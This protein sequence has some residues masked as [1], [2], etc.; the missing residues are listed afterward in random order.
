MLL[1]LFSV[2][3]G[4]G[5]LGWWARS[6]AA[7]E[8]VRRVAVQQGSRALGMDLFIGQIE[9]PSLVPLRV[10]A[11]TISLHATDAERSGLPLARLDEIEVELGSLWALREQRLE[12]ESLKITAPAVRLALV[13]GQL[14]DFAQLL[15]RR[16]PRRDPLR[17]Q[18][19]ELTVTGADASL[20][21][22]P[23][24]L[25]LELQDVALA[26]SQDE[27]GDGAGELQV[28]EVEVAIA[29]IRERS[30]LPPTPF[31]VEGSR[32][33]VPRADLPLR[34]GPLMLSGEVRLPSPPGAAEARP[35]SYSAL[36][37]AEVELPRLREIWGKLPQMEGALRVAVTARGEGGPPS[38]SF[39]VRG[40]DVAVHVEKPRPR[41]FRVGSPSLRGRV[42]G[43]LVH[44]E[45]SWVD[46]ALGRVD[47]EG[48]V[49][50]DGD[51]PFQVQVELQD[52]ELAALLDAVTVRHSWVQ[53]GMSGS[54]SLHGQLKGGFAAWGQA[55][56]DTRRLLVQ[57]GAWD[58]GGP[59]STILQVPRTH[60]STGITMGPR[61]CLLEP[62]RISAPGTELQAS[63]DFLFQRPVGLVIQV[64]GDRL[65]LADLGGAI[66]GQEV[67]G[68]GAISARVEGPSRDLDI[69][70]SLQLEDFTFRGWNFGSVQGDVH[71]HARD[72]LEFTRLV[73]RRGEST[74]ESEV[75]VLFA[76]VR[77]GGSRE[78]LEIDVE[79]AVPK[80]YGRAQ[81]LL[82]IFFGSAVDLRGPA[83]GQVH[84]WGRPAALQGRGQVHTGPVRYLWEDF[85][86]LDLRVDVRDGD[87]FLDDAWA[88]K[89][90][91]NAVF[92]RGLIGR[93]RRVDIELRIPDMGVEELRPV[94]RSLPLTG[95]L[96]GYA[97]LTGDLSAVDVATELRLIDSAYRGKP[98]PPST[99]E[100]TVRE[101]EAHGRADLLGGQLV[102]EG[103]LLL[104][105]LWPHSWGVAARDLQITPFLPSSVLARDS[106]VRASVDGRLEG[107]GTLRDGW[108]RVALGLDRLTLERAGQRLTNAPDTPIE[109]ALRDGA[110]CFDRVRLVDPGGGTDLRL[111]GS[112]RLDGPLDLSLSGPVDVRLVDL[113][114]DT[115]ERTEARSL[116]LAELHISGPSADALDVRGRAELRD[117][118]VKTVYFPHP[119]EISYAR[120]ALA[121][122]RLL[123]EEFEGT[124][125]GGK[126]THAAGSWIRLDG[127]SF[128]P[129]EYGLQARCFDCTLQYPSFMPPGTADITLRFAG[130]APDGLVL[131]GDIGVSSMV[132]REPIN[133]QRS[134]L[135][136]GERA[137]EN[138]AGSDQPPLFSFDIDVRSSEEGVAISNNL[139][140]LRGTARALHVGG[141]TNTVTLDGLLGIDSG[142]FRFKG[143][144]FQIEPGT[145]TFGGGS[146]W[147]PEMSI[148]MW[149]DVESRSRVYRITYDVSGPLNGPTLIASSDPAL[150]E[151]DIVSLLLFGLTEEDLARASLADLGAAIGNL[152]AS[153]ITEQAATEATSVLDTDGGKV[154]VQDFLPDRVEVVPVYTDT[155]GSTTLWVVGSKEIVPGLLDGEVGLGIRRGGAS[156]SAKARLQLLRNLYLE[157]SWLN[158]ETASTAYGNFG[159]DM[160]LE[161][162]LD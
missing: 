24:G 59:Y 25:G 19:G 18:I 162:E 14:R 135:A 47:F 118:L 127:S 40:E 68:W 141:D 124:L 129:R 97:H 107:V 117:A 110:L 81:D 125:G 31:A 10:R 85:E 155:T 146:D 45:P 131:S 142:S 60:V 8:L 26:F 62:A 138:L 20:S 33:A 76:D 111:E 132:L 126:L 136:I 89:A 69:G 91:G 36:A 21:V 50:L 153:T 93:D 159:L 116:N 34:T 38:V 13:G 35:L 43:K 44:I 56:I 109:V 32:V 106:T 1:A 63:V 28:G 15:R 72:D 27:Q 128:R 120:V 64:E 143:H 77:R 54:A 121:D 112:A 92:A 115:L 152:G 157:G 46:W 7:M 130:E 90:S 22:A 58:R 94:R 95:R 70:G 55:D 160:K 73:A 154:T 87:L 17:V 101:H 134:A 122:R 158:D 104:E 41:V 37:E 137:T 123:L 66:A 57:A 96:S 2:T 5:I 12:I 86:A 23:L 29:D 6:D 78:G 147:F 65:D 150:A 11:G 140:N 151:K 113:F 84:L 42:E 80:G 99:L 71:W 139:G 52:V 51:L 133:W 148:R 49:G 144:D 102:A 105:Q 39:D 75:R 161:L 119:I 103:Q 4:L 30:S 114:T 88:R 100:A 3:A 79:V 67:D 82:P 156:Y 98:L 149:S 16:Q 108:N 53:M 145:A 48:S 9:V 74:Y 61:H 83:W